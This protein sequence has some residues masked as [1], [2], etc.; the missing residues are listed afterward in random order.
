MA[1]ERLTSEE[2]ENVHRLLQLPVEYIQ[3]RGME[4]QWQ[5]V[6]PLLQHPDGNTEASQ[7]KRCKSLKHKHIHPVT[8]QYLTSPSYVQPPGWAIPG[9]RDLPRITK[10]LARVALMR[11]EAKY[12]TMTSS[13]PKAQLDQ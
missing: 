7:C 5:R 8:G 12:P 3:C 6:Q 11:V 10:A 1:R 2:E 13:L 4:H 9:R